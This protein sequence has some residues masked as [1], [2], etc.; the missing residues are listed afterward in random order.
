MVKGNSAGR[1]AARLVPLQVQNDEREM[2]GEA[3]EAEEQGRRR[4]NSE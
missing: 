3:H 2:K 4:R 1:R